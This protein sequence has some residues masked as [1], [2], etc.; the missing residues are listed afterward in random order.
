MGFIPKMEFDVKGLQFATSINLQ[1]VK[2]AFLEA[3]AWKQELGRVS[4]VDVVSATAS[5]TLSASAQM[6]QLMQKQLQKLKLLH[7]FPLL[8]KTISMFSP[9]YYYTYKPSPPGKSFYFRRFIDFSLPDL[10]D[11]AMKPGVKKPTGGYAPFVKDRV[12]VSGKKRYQERFTRMGRGVYSEQDAFALG[13][14]LVDQSAAAS[15]R[16]KPVSGK[17]KKLGYNI[18][19]W[20]MLSGKFYRKGDR[21]I[22]S[23][24]YRIDSSGEL[25]Q[26]TAK[27]VLANMERGRRKT[28]VKRVKRQPAVTVDM[29]QFDSMLNRMMRLRYV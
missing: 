28:R 26:I 14:H 9:D 15:F 1:D 6:Q 8:T 10:P 12:Y 2:P 13:G 27:G 22:E 18:P 23:N 21:M 3:S 17:P 19:G 5:A 29:K 24:L 7:K 25:A 11:G 20:N 16:V 4:D